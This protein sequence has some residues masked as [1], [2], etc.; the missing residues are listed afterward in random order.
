MKISA[1]AKEIGE[2]EL[3]ISIKVMKDNLDGDM[4]IAFN[5]EFIMEPLK[6]WS[7][8]GYDKDPA[9]KVTLEIIEP[10]K[11]MVMLPKGSTKTY[12]VIMPIKLPENE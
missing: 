5:P 6:L 2:S 10:N 3:S 4:K 12:A 1:K 9:N 8:F 11:P 7:T